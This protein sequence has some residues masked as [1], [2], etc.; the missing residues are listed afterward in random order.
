MSH[1]LFN[2]YMDGM[3]RE[4]NVRRAG[5]AECEWWQV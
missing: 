2:L 3:V 4:V 1:S 5:V